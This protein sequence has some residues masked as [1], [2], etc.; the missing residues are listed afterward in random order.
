MSAK[1]FYTVKGARQGPTTLD[2][3][4]SLAAREELNRSD[5]IW[6]E[7][8]GAWQ[9]AGSTAD[10]FQGLPPDL[11][12][13]M[14]ANTASADTMPPPLP[15]AM[16]PT[17]PGTST[18][19]PAQHGSLFYWY[20]HVLKSYAGFEGRATR[21]E[22]WSFFLVNFCIGFLTALI[23]ALCGDSGVL[24]LLYGFATL[25]PYLAVGI[26][27]MHDTD[28]SGWWILLPIGNLIYWAEDGK[29]GSNRFGLN[30]KTGTL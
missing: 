12:P 8:M 28:R 22:F 9:P 21:R 26:R 15:P 17:M 2:E 16:P 5:L 27:R 6:A 19:N 13:G 14:V 25:I 29:P 23:A 18:L 3:L 20:V 11:D 7:G 1:Y 10:I 30:P 24:S 4:K